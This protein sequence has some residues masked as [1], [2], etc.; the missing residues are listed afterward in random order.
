MRSSGV[1]SKLAYGSGRLRNEAYSTESNLNASGH[2]LKLESKKFLPLK[3]ERNLI[4]YGD[5][6]PVII[7]SIKFLKNAWLNSTS[8]MILFLV[9]II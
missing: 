2:L 8:S 9:V 3:S 5:N 6:D 1:I 7:L 4:I